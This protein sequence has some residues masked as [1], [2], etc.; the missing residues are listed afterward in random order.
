MPAT[1]QIQVQPIRQVSVTLTPTGAVEVSVAFGVGSSGI[2]QLTG[3][4]TAGPGSGSQAA[5]LAESGV[6]AGS[7]TNADIT[8]DAKGRVTAAANGGDPTDGFTLDEGANI[9]AGT[10]TGSMIGTDPL[11]KLA[12]WGGTPIVRPVT[13]TDVGSVL[14][15]GFDGVNFTDLETTI[16][17]LVGGI[18]AINQRLKDIGAVAPG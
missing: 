2:T 6:A 14:T 9:A 17:G 4:V 5:T 3:D 12:L 18:N 13:L 16:N 8:V 1:P 7:Y 15:T 10:V 11:Q